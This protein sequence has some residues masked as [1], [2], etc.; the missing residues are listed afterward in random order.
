MSHPVIAVYAKSGNTWTLAGHADLL[1][2]RMLLAH[3]DLAAA[4][5]A[6]PQGFQGVA[7]LSWQAGG[8]LHSELVGI[9]EV[10][11]IGSWQ[12]H[13][14]GTGLELAR[15]SDAPPIFIPPGP[16]GEGFWCVLFPW[17]SFC[18]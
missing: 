5:A 17:A 11:P 3:A 9:R 13:V 4:L 16:G 12:G 18:G 1:L 14:G 10:G 7:H 8:V 6:H 2:P 15:P